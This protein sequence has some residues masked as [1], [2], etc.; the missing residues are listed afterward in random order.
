MES[1]TNAIEKPLQTTRSYSDVYL[2][3]KTSPT[4]EQLIEQK[5]KTRGVKRKKLFEYDDEW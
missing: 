3:R 2:D 5:E 1:A 4:I